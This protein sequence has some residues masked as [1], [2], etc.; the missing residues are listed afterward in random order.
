VDDIT[1]F[2]VIT[3][4]AFAWYAE[5]DVEWAVLEVGM[6]GRL[7]ATNVV[8]PAVA[9]ITPVSYDHVAT[10]GNTLTKI[11]REKA[12]IVKP[13]V[14]VVSAPQPEEALS[15][16]EATCQRH[17]APLVLVGRD[18][19]WEAAEA[20]LDGQAFV[21]RHGSEALENLWIPLLGKHQLSNAATAV[22]TLAQL[23][24]AGVPISESAIRDGLGTVRWPGRMEI[25]GRNPF[26]VADGAH[27][28]DSAQK[29]MAAL[30]DHF[31]YENLI[32]ILGA[33]PDHATTDMLNTLLSGA[34]RAIV[35]QSRHPRA[36][37]PLQIQA[38]AVP[39]GF[40]LETCPSVPEAL[41]L[42]LAA[43][44]PQDLVCFTGSLFIVA[45]AREAWFARQGM[46]PLPSD[47][48]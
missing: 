47:P 2:E 36:A 1:T 30:D 10:L 21:L 32:L 19:T 29:L 45:E 20:D 40:Q 27:N 31:D 7:D 28:V 46:A 9:V 16:V 42:A 3:G 14:P 39:L 23:R 33:S 5:R 26:V 38:Q 25:L 12:G 35:T 18:W 37:T 24:E 13:G 8:E 22:A 44:G 43:A 17:N 11:A 4:L 41:D 15:V 6:G 34:Q 48:V